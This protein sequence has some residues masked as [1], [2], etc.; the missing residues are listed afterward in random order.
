MK[1]SENKHTIYYK[2]QYF[3]HKYSYS[4]FPFYLAFNIVHIFKCALLHNP[5]FF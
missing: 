3:W 5:L 4:F 1:K 2:I